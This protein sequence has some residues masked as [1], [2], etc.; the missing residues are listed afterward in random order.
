MDRWTFDLTKGI[1]ILR[2]SDVSVNRNGV[3]YGPCQF[4]VD[5]ARAIRF[6]IPEPPWEISILPPF[7]HA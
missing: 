3:I 4:H 5:L 1:Y 2:D 6:A 7:F